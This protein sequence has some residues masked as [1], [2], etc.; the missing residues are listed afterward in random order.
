VLQTRAVTNTV[1]SRALARAAEILGSTD[2]L[3]AHLGVS[4]RQLALW[5]QGRVKPPDD[6]F[7]MVVDV[8][9]E[10]DLEEMRGARDLEE[11]R[12]DATQP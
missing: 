4:A 5:M 12:G 11:M 8:L 1:F 7:L 6:V 3:R 10:R 9:A 2:A